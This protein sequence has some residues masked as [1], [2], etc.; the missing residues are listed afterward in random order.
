[1]GEGMDEGMDYYQLFVLFS[2]SAALNILIHR[3][4]YLYQYFC[5]INL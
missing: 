1:M 2:N 5:G 4:V 3:F